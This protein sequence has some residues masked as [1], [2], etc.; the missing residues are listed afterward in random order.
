MLTEIK[1][2]N[3]AY[4]KPSPINNAYSNPRK[5]IAD[6]TS[7]RLGPTENNIGANGENSSASTGVELD[8][9]KLASNKEP[10]YY[11]E[12]QEK[13]ANAKN[14][15]QKQRLEN[16]LKRKS[17]RHGAAA[18][19][20]QMKDNVKRVSQENRLFDKNKRVQERIENKAKRK[21]L[22]P[23]IVTNAKPNNKKLE[24]K[25]KNNNNGMEDIVNFD[26]KSPAP[27]NKGR[28]FSKALEVSKRE[29]I[30]MGRINIHSSSVSFPGL[31]NPGRAPFN[32][33]KVTRQPIKT[34]KTWDNSKYGKLMKDPLGRAN[35][36]QNKKP[37]TKMKNEHSPANYLNP[38]TLAVQGDAGQTEETNDMNMVANRAGRP[39]NSNVLMNDPVNYQD[40][41][42][43]S[44]QSANQNAMFSNI[45]SSGMDPSTV[46]PMTGMVE[47]NRTDEDLNQMQ[48]TPF[49]KK[50]CK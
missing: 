32:D 18:S 7:L 11:P 22:D 20:S 30:P 29:N 27:E 26:Y 1:K 33:P 31:N 44:A 2:D 23:S 4:K 35:K 43:V 25:N 42:K 39:V 6:Y 40:P 46:N 41:S 17:T 3:M 9:V 50:Y 16:K 13:I 36:E 48:A 28:G 47:N 45:A 10:T 15:K 14:A 21:G 38:N 34:T 8:P 49:A 19:R 24:V 12:L 37:P 5:V